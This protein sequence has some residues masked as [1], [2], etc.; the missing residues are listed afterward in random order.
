M[1]LARLLSAAI[2]ALG[3][4]SVGAQT[5][6]SKPVHGIVAFGTGGV[7]DSVARIVGQALSEK[8]RQALVIENR[9]GAGGN[10]G[11]EYVVKS[12]PDGY[13]INFATQALTINQVVTPAPGFH[14]MKDLA[15]VSLLGWSDFVLLVHPSVPART[16]DEL[17]AY[18][19]ANPRKLY[20]GSSSLQGA[21]AMEQFKSLAGIEIERVPYKEISSLT[22]DLL[23]GRLQVYFPPIAPVLAH[24]Q[25]GKLV[26]LAVSSTEP[27][28]L[29]P[30]VKS[31]KAVLPKLEAA[32]WYAVLAPAATPRTIIDR[33][34]AEL[35][36]A[37]D[38]PEVRERFAKL[39]VR[40]QP[41]TPEELR[42][43]LERD[44]AQ[45]E[46]LARRGV[47]KAGN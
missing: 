18:G 23:A 1:T 31:I 6:P 44:I 3:V 19:K 33:L 28:A 13:T 36:W 17:I 32:T 35:R 7:T 41:S 10:I 2:L 46:D 34:N 42:S 12:A 22:T 26:P 30:G 40:P 38:Q 20:Y 24:L 15:P 9:A 43:V 11:T 16:V 5:Y 47:M 21:Y 8:W 45:I 14:A 29:L 25:S 39:A 37:L 27:L 4:Q